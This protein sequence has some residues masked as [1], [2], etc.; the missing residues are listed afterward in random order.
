MAVAKVASHSKWGLYLHKQ[1]L[2]IINSSSSSF[3][4]LLLV[5]LLMLLLPYCSDT[6]LH[7][8]LPIHRARHIKQQLDSPLAR[9]GLLS[10]MLLLLLLPSFFAKRVV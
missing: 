5:L 2:Q 9:L 1:R 3:L 4:L 7:T 10:Y 6:H 8:H